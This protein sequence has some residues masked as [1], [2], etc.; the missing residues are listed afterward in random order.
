MDA[1]TKGAS[2]GT[3]AYLYNHDHGD[4]DRRVLD[5]ICRAS[6]P[7]YPKWLRQEDDHVPLRIGL[8]VNLVKGK[9]LPETPHEEVRHPYE[10]ATFMSVRC[11]A[12]APAPARVDAT[13]THTIL[14]AS[15]PAM[16][17]N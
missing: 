15:V 2:G 16:A 7:L 17:R 13:R 6:G 4:I 10:D 5:H 14:A 12:P 8:T 3:A 9:V 1:C 11:P